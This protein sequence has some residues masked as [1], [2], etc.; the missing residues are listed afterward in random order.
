M[1]AI[2]LRLIVGLLVPG[3]QDSSRVVKAVRAMLD[4]LY[5]AQFP[6]HTSDYLDRLQASLASFHEH[7]VV[8][9]DLEAQKH[10]NFPKLHGLSHYVTSIRLFGTIDNYNTEQTKCLHITFTKDAYHAT[11]CKDKF[12]QMTVWLECCEKVQ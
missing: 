10:F 4:F 3:G 1:C 2:L 5:L 9:I 6:C 7:K 11:N 8:F 12:Y